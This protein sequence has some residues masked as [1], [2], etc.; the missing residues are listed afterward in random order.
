MVTYAG[1]ERKS[2]N[3]SFT[4]TKQGSFASSST[5]QPYGYPHVPYAF[6]LL[7][8]WVF[9]IT[10]HL[11]ILPLCSY[12]GFV[13]C[14]SLPFRRGD[15]IPPNTPP[16]VS[17]CLMPHCTIAGVICAAAAWKI[18]V[19]FPQS[20][21]CFAFLITFGLS[22]PQSVQMEMEKSFIIKL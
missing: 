8:V 1:T 12:I 7:C 16:A 17:Y 21:Y 22:S 15:V 18:F 6:N 19:C 4:F 9:G 2:G 3:R 14:C 10:L 11:S 5:P 20:N 13:F